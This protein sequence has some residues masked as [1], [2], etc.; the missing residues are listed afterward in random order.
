MKKTLYTFII[1]CLITFCS[2]SGIGETGVKSNETGYEAK[3]SE[4]MIADESNIIGIKM[5]DS[6]VDVEKLIRE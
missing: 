2:C 4:L 5:G 3:L 6:Y 1:I